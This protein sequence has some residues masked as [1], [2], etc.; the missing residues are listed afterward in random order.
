MGDTDEDRNGNPAY[1]GYLVAAWSAA[2]FI[3]Y[4][5]GLLGLDG[6]IWASI[7]RD[8]LIASWPLAVLALGAFAWAKRPGRA[9]RDR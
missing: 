9:S 4:V 5:F 6:G 2:L 7:R 8:A 1:V 3:Y